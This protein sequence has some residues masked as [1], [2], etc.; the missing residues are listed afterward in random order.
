MPDIEQ[1]TMIPDQELQ[2][3]IAFTSIP[4]VGRVRMGL[5][6][7]RF[8]SLEA[9]W[10]AGASELRAAGLDAN[11]VDAIT[12]GRGSVEPERELQRI[13]DA[14]VT[15]L[16]WHDA[17]YPRL[18]REI[19]DLPP[20]IYISGGFIQEDERSV[21][22]V[23]TRRPTAYG[24]EVARHLSGELAQAGITVVSGL[25]RGID[26]A[27]HRASLDAG[28]ERSPCLARGWTSPTLQSTPS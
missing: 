18:L 27:A 20:V 13:R 24:K 9:A 15:A 5:M 28:D 25:A 26:G 7:E 17:D 8:G 6:E 16:T 12:S 2:Y 21:T 1:Q 4:T 11:V 23:G 22:V 3:W 10:Q 14:N 19:D